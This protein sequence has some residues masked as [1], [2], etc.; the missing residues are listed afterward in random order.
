MMNDEGNIRTEEWYDGEVHHHHHH[1]HHH[2]DNIRVCFQG[3]QDVAAAPIQE[4]LEHARYKA[5]KVR[6]KEV[7]ATQLVKPPSDDGLLGDL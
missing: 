6:E 4:H 5:E 7:P 2:D 3:H 1:H